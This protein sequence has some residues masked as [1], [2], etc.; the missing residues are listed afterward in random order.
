[1]LLEAGAST[2]VC[3]G[4]GQAL[5]LT[6]TLAMSGLQNRNRRSCHTQ[7]IINSSSILRPSPADLSASPW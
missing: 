3:N 4:M 7:K 1:M 5:I 6:I 2:T